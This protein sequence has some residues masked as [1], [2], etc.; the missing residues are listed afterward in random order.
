MRGGGVEAGLDIG[1]GEVELAEAD[2][3]VVEVGGRS[4]EGAA[5]RVG[6]TEEEGGGVGEQAE[7]ADDGIDGGAGAVEAA[8]DVVSG[9]LIEEEGAEDLVAAMAGIGG[10]GEEGEGVG[11]LGHIRHYTACTINSKFNQNIAFCL[12]SHA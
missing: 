10:P 2:D 12:D 11:G 1:D 5:G 4:G 8:G 7:V 3:F 6:G 9:E